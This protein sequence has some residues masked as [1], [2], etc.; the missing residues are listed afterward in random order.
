MVSH[1]QA[2]LR[3]P[4]RAQLIETGVPSEHVDQIVDLGFHAAERALDTLDN[5]VW[6]SGD[7]RISL[8]ALGVAISLAQNRLNELQQA[9]LQAGAKAGMRASSVMVEA[10]HG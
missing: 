2:R 1:S 8:T 9:M 10:H 6:S 5:I 7:K 4:V 3:T